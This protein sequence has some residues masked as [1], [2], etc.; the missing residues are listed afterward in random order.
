[1]ATLREA[2]LYCVGLV[3]PGTSIQL[4]G[5]VRGF[6]G[7][8]HHRGIV[9]AFNGGC[10]VFSL[11]SGALLRR[12]GDGVPEGASLAVECL[13]VDQVRRGAWA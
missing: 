8:T 13:N 6:V 12:E 7:C 9:V 5:E 4:A 1:M 2:P 11:E 3:Q 10:A